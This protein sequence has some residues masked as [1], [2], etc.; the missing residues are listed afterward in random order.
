[1][2]EVAAQVAAAEPV[3]DPNAAP[4]VDPKQDELA[5]RFASLANKEKQIRQ[6]AKEA[7]DRLKQAMELENKYKEQSKKFSKEEIRKNPAA[8]LES[9]DMTMEEYIQASLAAADGK[10][11][12]SDVREELKAMQA[13]LDKVESD[14][15]AREKAET[16]KAEKAAID[17]YKGQIESYV[18]ADLDNYELI[19]TYGCFDQVYDVI[20]EYYTANGE[21]I[22]PDPTI[23]V[24]KAAEQVESYLFDYVSKGRTAKKF[25]PKEEPVIDKPLTPFEDPMLKPQPKPFSPMAPTISN[26]VATATSSAPQQ[27]VSDL[28]RKRR[29]AAMIK[30]N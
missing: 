21:M 28:E 24:Q 27:A 4:A 2:S 30:F 15:E 14:R 19:N 23:N 20:E 26:K 10:P 1:M 3:V 18:K 22:D 8:Y 7:N 9:I 17:N 29:A 6:Q 25:S 13:K 5:P 12:E 11:L 16:E